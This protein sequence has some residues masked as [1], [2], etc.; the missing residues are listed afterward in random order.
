MANPATT[1]FYNDLKFKLRQKN[2][3]ANLLVVSTKRLKWHNDLQVRLS[4]AATKSRHLTGDAIDF[5]VLD[6]NRDGR[7]DA[8]DVNIVYDILNKEIIGNKGGIGTYKNESG[9][10][11]RQ[12]IHI[13][14]RGYLARWAR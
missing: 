13:D 2:Y 8:K 11:N 6:V 9:F 4:G 14:C 1:A 10:V 7:A 12:M 3:S 5:I